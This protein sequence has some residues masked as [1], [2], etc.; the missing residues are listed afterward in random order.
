[1]PDRLAEVRRSHLRTAYLSHRAGDE[2][3][4]IRHAA[5]T[6]ERDLMRRRDALQ[7]KLESDPSDE[8]SGDEY[9]T[10]LHDLARVGQVWPGV[11][12]DGVSA[13]G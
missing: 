12:E 9:R 10:V 8:E 7:R 13:T 3:T 11:R 4:R 2:Q 5:M 1:M 6:L